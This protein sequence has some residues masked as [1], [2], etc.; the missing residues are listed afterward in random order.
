[1]LDRF[2]VPT[3]AGNE[4]HEETERRTDELALFPLAAIGGQRI[5]KRVRLP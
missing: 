5:K 1:L 4:L 2:G 3:T